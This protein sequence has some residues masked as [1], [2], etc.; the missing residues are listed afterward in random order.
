MGAAVPIPYSEIE[1]YCRLKNIFL[2]SERERL[3]TLIDR[4]DREWMRLHHEKMD[5]EKKSSSSPPPPPSHSPPR[6]GGTRN[7]RRPVS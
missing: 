3:V 4:L 6:G 1:A 2:P 5:K 7:P